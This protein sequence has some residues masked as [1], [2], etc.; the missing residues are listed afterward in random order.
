MTLE[1]HILLEKI[2]EEL[3]KREMESRKKGQKGKEGKEGKP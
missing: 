1:Q 2:N 3:M